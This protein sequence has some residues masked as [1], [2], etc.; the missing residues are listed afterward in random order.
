MGEEKKYTDGVNYL[1]YLASKEKGKLI[2]EA[3][4][5]PVSKK[6]SKKGKPPILKVEEN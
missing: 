4:L 6:M 5:K 3:K 1:G 2:K